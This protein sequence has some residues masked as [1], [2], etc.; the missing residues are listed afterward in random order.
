VT[1]IEKFGIS[2]IEKEVIILLLLFISSVLIRFYKIPKYL[3][4]G[5]EQGRDAQIIQNIYKLGQFTLIGPKT[6]LEGT[7]HGPWYYYLM[8]LPY[9][10]SKGNPI[11]AAFFLILVCSSTPIVIYFLFK[12]IY[13]SKPLAFFAGILCAFSF[14]LVVYARWVSNV[15]LA[16]PFIALAFFCIWKYKVSQKGGY[17]IFSV[18]FA[19]FASQFEMIL[20]FQ[21]GFVYILLFLLKI[22]K[23]PRF[24]SLFFSFLGLFIILSPLIIFDFRHQHISFNSIIAMFNGTSLTRSYEFNFQNFLYFYQLRIFEV[25]KRTL[26]LPDF[27]ILQII[28]LVIFIFGLFRYWQLKLDRTVLKFFLIWSFMSLPVIFLAANL[29][30]SYVGTGLGFI[31]LFCLSSLGLWKSRGMRFLFVVLF[32]SI[33]FSWNLGL[34]Y[35]NQNKNIFFVTIQK[36]LNLGDQKK[37][38]EF[39]HQ[40]SARQPYRFEAFTIP[41]LHPEGWQYLLKYYYSKDIISTSAKQVY[42]VIEKEVYPVWENKWIEDLG[43]TRLVDERIFGLLRVQKRLV[44]ST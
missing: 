23:I 36:D 5:Y 25:I 34:Y 39:I 2:L 22:I 6:S 29:D 26:F 17:F 30:Q 37:V 13:K 10:L 24:K 7:F 20:F 9:F 8:T 19:S 44:N 12:S 3:F 32:I 14:E 42:I 4:F 16:V 41:S 27:L 1:R 18:F 40:D 21:F 38:L 28:F 35:L 15:T 43:N 11:V 33:I 31:G